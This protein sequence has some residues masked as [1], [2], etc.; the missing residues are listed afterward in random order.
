M[1]GGLIFDRSPILIL[2][3]VSAILNALQLLAVIHLDAQQLAGVNIAAGAIIALIANSGTV[4]IA[5]GN[6]AA[7]RKG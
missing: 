3:A 1:N 2:G 4:Q 7:A 5:A 6:A